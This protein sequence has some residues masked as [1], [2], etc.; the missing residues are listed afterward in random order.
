M[1]MSHDIGRPPLTQVRERF[2]VLH[3]FGIAAED[4]TGYSSPVLSLHGLDVVLLTFVLGGTG[5]HVLHDTEHAIL[6]PSFAVT[7]TGELHGLITDGDGLDVVNVYLDLDAR[8][9]EPLGP[10]LGPALATL[11]PVGTSPRVRLPQV[12]LDDVPP[13][14]ALLALLVR[15]TRSPGLG[16]EEALIALRR[17][18]LIEC[19]RALAAHGFLPEPRLASRADAATEIVRAHI[20]RTFTEHHTLADLADLAHLERTYLSRAFAARMGET[21]SAYLAR[22]RVGYAMAQLRS[23][24]LAIAEIA[25]AAGFRDLSHFGRTFRRATGQSPRDYRRTASI[26]PNGRQAQAEGARSRKRETA[27]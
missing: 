16:T 19:A 8:P 27:D 1:Q 5:R 10:E 7:R 11:F 26:P 21:I 22:L 12:T 23:T 4:F 14:R 25:V 13:V 2:A 24:D 15:E 17:M 18:L 6:G 9:I 20:E 3:D